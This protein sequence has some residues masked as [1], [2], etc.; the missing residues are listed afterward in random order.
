MAI[1][2]ET[3]LDGMHVLITGASGDIGSQT[4]KIVAS[5][6]AKISLTGRNEEKLEQLANELKS[7][8]T[9]VHF[10]K[11]DLSN[12]EERENLI[13]SCEKEIGF[14][15][16]LVN[17]AGVAGGEVLEELGE[18]FVANMLHVNVTS[19]MMLTK[20]VYP[21][22]KEKGFGRIVNVSSLSGIRGTQGNSAYAASKFALRGF[23]QSLA[24]EAAPHRITVNAVCPGYVD[25][26][27]G[28]SAIKRRA[29]EKGQTFEQKYEEVLKGLPSGR[30]TT[31]IEVANTIGFLLTDA[32]PTLTG[33]SILL[34]GG[35]VMK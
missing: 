18:E 11:A 16:G 1:F 17:C 27:M 10:V 15:S 2:S 32:A 8:G 28:R 26:K 31:P 3:A 25:T 14:V 34:S 6:G 29:E 22:M 20:L 4:A 30:I 13:R 12:Q 21:K 24:V 19:A 9:A 23:T 5:M 7:D 33:E 35:S